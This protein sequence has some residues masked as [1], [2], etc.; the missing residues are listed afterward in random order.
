MVGILL[1]YWGDLFS[2]AMLV[3]GRVFVIFV[4]LGA[5]E[6]GL[7]MGVVERGGGSSTTLNSSEGSIFFPNH[8]KQI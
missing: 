3:S 5:D 7:E 2:G 6:I 1:S 4:I 8:L